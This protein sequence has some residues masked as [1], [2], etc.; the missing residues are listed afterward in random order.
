[1]KIKSTL[2]KFT[3]LTPAQ[4][5]V[6]AMLGLTGLVAIFQKLSSE[7]GDLTRHMTGDEVMTTS[8]VIGTFA[9]SAVLLFILMIG[10]KIFLPIVG[11]IL[12]EPAMRHVRMTAVKS[13]DP[14]YVPH[15]RE[16]GKI[17]NRAATIVS[18]H[19]GC[20]S[21]RYVDDPTNGPLSEVK[22]FLMNLEDLD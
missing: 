7:A 10:I 17:F 13:G 15:K 22:E 3:A 9:S 2:N 11:R 19:P 20:V 14:I 18:V 1:M 8:E 4:I 5:T 12:W 6:T 16:D 21:V